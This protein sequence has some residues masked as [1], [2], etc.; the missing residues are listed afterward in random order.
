MPQKTKSPSDGNAGDMT[1]KISSTDDSSVP[2]RAAHV[3]P[4]YRYFSDAIL[5]AHE[6]L[7]LRT[8]AKNSLIGIIL[9]PDLMLPQKE[10][11]MSVVALASEFK[12]KPRYIYELEKAGLIEI[13]RKNNVIHVTNDFVK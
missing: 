13:D 9:H 7:D 11:H 2:P 12:T 5:S 8:P 1:K 3:N 4:K 6:I 10:L